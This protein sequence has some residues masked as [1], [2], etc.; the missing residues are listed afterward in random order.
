[1][2]NFAWI[3]NP[4]APADKLRITLVI[5]LIIHTFIL[6]GIGI[7]QS[8]YKKHKQTTLNITLQHS[9]KPNPEDNYFESNIDA[10]S[11]TK[12]LPSNKNQNFTQPIH[13][14]NIIITKNSTQTFEHHVF[15]KKNHLASTTKKKNTLLHTAQ[16]P[17]KRI[18]SSTT[19]ED[20]DKN[21]LSRWQA[22]LENIGNQHYPKIALKNDIRGNLRLMVAINKDGSV[23]KVTIRQS[24]GHKILDDAALMIVSKAAPFE[25]LPNEITQDVDILEIIR[26][27]QFRGNFATS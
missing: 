8:F 6:L 16:T 24:S 14:P 18:I 25:P 13:N 10:N 3:I 20:R 11:M 7:H 2:N 5:A 22:Y 26:T 19:H 27:W 21:Y 4:Q 17:R 9:S 23:N 15:K 12:G 1:M